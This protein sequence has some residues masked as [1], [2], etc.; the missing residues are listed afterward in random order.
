MFSIGK[1]KVIKAL[2]SNND[3]QLKYLGDL[4]TNLQWSLIEDECISFICILYGMNPGELTKTISEMRYEKTMNT[5]S[6][7]KYLP[8]TKEA[9]ILNIKRAHYQCSIWKNVNMDIP[10]DLLPENYGWKMDISNKCLEPVQLTPETPI[11]PEFLLTLIFCGCDSANPCVSGN[12][13]CNKGK[14]KCS[15]LCKCRGTC[16]NG[17]TIEDEYNI[18]N[19][20]DN[21]DEE[22]ME[23]DSENDDLSD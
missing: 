23:L 20:L 7:L 12:C 9:I 16:S 21:G 10:S 1:K 19:E 22:D 11:S 5:I 2:K 18:I 6:D 8:P 15:E 13:G 3:L 14:F 17:P 4:D